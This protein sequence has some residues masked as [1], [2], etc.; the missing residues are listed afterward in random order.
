M[1]QNL[2]D[3]VK[4]LGI[5]KKEFYS[6]PYWDRVRMSK[7]NTIPTRDTGEEHVYCINMYRYVRSNKVHCMR[8]LLFVEKSNKYI[9]YKKWLST[10]HNYIDTGYPGYASLIL[11][12][13]MFH[14]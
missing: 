1:E 11:K 14:I 6:I 9:K 12:K 3:F 5:T 8:T 7:M 4:N 13:L 2:L 10:V